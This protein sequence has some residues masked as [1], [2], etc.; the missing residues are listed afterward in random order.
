MFQSP[1]R[2]TTPLHPPPPPRPTPH[3]WA[4]LR[5][6]LKNLQ[7]LKQQDEKE[8]RRK[9]QFAAVSSIFMACICVFSFGKMQTPC[10]EGPTDLYRHSGVQ[11]KKSVNAPSCVSDRHSLMRICKLLTLYSFFYG[12]PLEICYRDPMPHLRQLLERFHDAPFESIY[13]DF[14]TSRFRHYTDIL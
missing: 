9:D 11:P 6:T 10:R 7:Q 14:M 8:D 1:S 3:H 5:Q 2:V 4:F 12:V 13:R